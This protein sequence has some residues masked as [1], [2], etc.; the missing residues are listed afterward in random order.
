MPFD[1]QRCLRTYSLF[2]FFFF[3]S[4]DLDLIVTTVFY[5]LT[6]VAARDWVD[7]G[8]R[9]KTKGLEMSRYLFRPGNGG[10]CSVMRSDQSYFF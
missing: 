7:N 4:I 2:F 10:R 5:V 3:Q 9:S 1:H 6:P 8:G